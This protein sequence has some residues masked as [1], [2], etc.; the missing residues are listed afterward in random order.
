MLTPEQ[1]PQA[2]IDAALEEYEAAA[3][4][5]LDVG[6]SFAAMIAAAL[7]RWPGVAADGADGTDVVLRVPLA[8]SA[9]GPGMHPRAARH[10]H[11]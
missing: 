7:N 3:F 6:R 1:I 5:R 11:C 2:A 10:N 8:A 4:A 9:P